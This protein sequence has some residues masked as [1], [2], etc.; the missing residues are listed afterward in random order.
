MVKKKLQIWQPEFFYGFLSCNSSLA[1]KDIDMIF[2]LFERSER[3]DYNA[4]YMIFLL[5]LFHC[6]IENYF[7]SVKI[8]P[9]AAS[10]ISESKKIKNVFFKKKWYFLMIFSTVQLNPM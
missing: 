9:I 7:Y 8:G 1:N 10:Q 6:N 3:E 2:F 4:L 5:L